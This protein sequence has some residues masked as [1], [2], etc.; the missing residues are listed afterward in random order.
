MK[1]CKKINL[2]CE[3]L[4]RDYL[5]DLVLVP[6]EILDQVKIPHRLPRE[7]LQTINDELTSYGV[8]ELLYC[9]SYIRAKDTKQGIHVDGVDYIWHAAINLPIKNT[10][11]TKFTWYDGEYTIEKKTQ[12]TGAIS[13]MT[14]ISFFELTDIKELAVTESIELDQAHLI[15]VDKPH[16]A[17]S[18]SDGYRWIFTMR[19]KGNPTFEELYD[20][21]PS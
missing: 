6:S 3:K 1:Y 18:N 13:G 21:L 11:N 12:D 20:K 19:F 16:N 2:K 9:Q 8:P 14:P 4:I 10:Q 7:L 5:L 15:R 17:E